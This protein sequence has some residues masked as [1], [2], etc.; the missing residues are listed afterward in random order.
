MPTYAVGM[1]VIIFLV[2][3]WTAVVYGSWTH[4]WIGSAL[5]LTLGFAALTSPRLIPPRYDG[6][7]P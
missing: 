2:S 6:D 3:F 5:W 1:N 7:E 4:D